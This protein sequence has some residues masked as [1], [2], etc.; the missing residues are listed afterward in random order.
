M[1][2]TP[3]KDFIILHCGGSVP[4]F[5]EQ[6]S[7]LDGGKLHSGN[8]YPMAAKGEH[9]IHE[10]NGEYQLYRKG[11]KIKREESNK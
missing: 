5:C 1:T 8:V 2:I 3:L 6:F 4:L 7:Y 9:F 11:K 10:S